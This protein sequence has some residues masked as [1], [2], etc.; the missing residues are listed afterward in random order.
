MGFEPIVDSSGRLVKMIVRAWA[1]DSCRLLGAHL[2][3]G[4]RGG[5]VHCIEGKE[6]GPEVWQLALG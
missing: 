1:G 4:T 5:D 2:R 3:P 6:D